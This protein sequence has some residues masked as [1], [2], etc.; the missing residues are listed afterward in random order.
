MYRCIDIWRAHLFGCAC[1][2]ADG[3]EAPAH[4]DELQHVHRARLADR[5]ARGQQDRRRDVGDVH[6]VARRLLQERERE[7]SIGIGIYVA[8]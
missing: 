4:L 5:L 6:L 8:I 2:L 3:G 7:I 1:A